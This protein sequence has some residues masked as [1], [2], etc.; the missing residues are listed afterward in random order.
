VTPER[1]LIVIT[2]LGVISAIGE[3]VDA[4]TTG[5]RHLIFNYYYLISKGKKSD[6]LII[7][8]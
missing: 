6:L 7:T 4:F 1:D 3:G 8:T 2:G 5:L